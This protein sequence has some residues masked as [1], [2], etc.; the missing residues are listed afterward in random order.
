MPSNKERVRAEWEDALAA[1]I[2]TSGGQGG[3]PLYQFD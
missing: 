1:S 3:L 2:L